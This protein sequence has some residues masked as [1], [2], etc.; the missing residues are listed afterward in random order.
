M[1][2]STS[3]GHFECACGACSDGQSVDESKIPYDT[4]GDDRPDARTT[5]T[6]A[7]WSSQT[8]GEYARGDAPNAPGPSGVF[9]SEREET[10]DERESASKKR[11]GVNYVGQGGPSARSTDS[12]RKAK[13]DDRPAPILSAPA[14]DDGGDS[15]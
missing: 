9:A 10:R 5:D 2:F 14:D 3:G 15:S 8:D 7:A 4:R 12:P 11:T 1:K 6:L 13:R